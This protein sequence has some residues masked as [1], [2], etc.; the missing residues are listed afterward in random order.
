MKSLKKNEINIKELVITS[1]RIRPDATKIKSLSRI[2][3]ELSD[4]ST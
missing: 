2:E 4:T 1:S 3:K